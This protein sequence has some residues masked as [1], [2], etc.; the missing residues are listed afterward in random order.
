M[1]VDRRGG[2]ALD[3]GVRGHHPVGGAVEWTAPSADRRAGLVQRGVRQH[4]IRSVGHGL[5]AVCRPALQRRRSGRLRRHDI[6]GGHVP[7]RRVGAQGDVQLHRR[8]GVASAD[9]RLAQLSARDAAGRGPAAIRVV[10]RG[11]ASRRHQRHRQPQQPRRRG[12]TATRRH[13]NSRLCVR[14]FADRFDA[15]RRNPADD[16]LHPAGPA[17]HEDVH[18]ARERDGD[19]AELSAPFP[20]V[21][22]HRRRP[23][24]EQPHDHGSPADRA[25]VHGRHRHV[26]ADDRDTSGGRQ[27]ADRTIRGGRGCHDRHVVGGGRV[28]PLRVLHP[29]E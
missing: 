3:A 26:G 17:V 14:Q 19:R 7:R 13:G 10:H 4:R 24:R 2:G 9:G 11:S 16:Q 6:L 22:R 15:D 25:P 28:R 5:R 1:F 8:D 29:R 18:R 21:G 23:A 20:I 27:R 12:N